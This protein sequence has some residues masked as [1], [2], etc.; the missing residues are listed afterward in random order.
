MVNLSKTKE[1]PY[2]DVWP[3]LRRL[4]DRYGAKRMVYANFFEYV[5]IGRAHV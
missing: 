2:R 3:F 1:L 4:Y 5:E